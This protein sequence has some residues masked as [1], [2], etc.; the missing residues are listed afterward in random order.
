MFLEP[1]LPTVTETILADQTPLVFFLFFLFFY[2]SS[3]F[4]SKLASLSEELYHF[5][6]SSVMDFWNC[7]L[8]VSSVRGC[9][10]FGE[11]EWTVIGYTWAMR[12]SMNVPKEMCTVDWPG[13]GHGFI[14]GARKWDKRRRE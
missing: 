9:L 2:S 13:L 4:L 7:R 12:S 11:P 3:F 6:R 10:Y 5:Q 1:H 8:M 14:P